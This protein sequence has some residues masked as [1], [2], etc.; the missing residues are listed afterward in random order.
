[1]LNMGIF[2]RL[3]IANR[4]FY[5]KE[6]MPRKGESD[7]LSDTGGMFLNLNINQGFFKAVQILLS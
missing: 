1:M 7:G 5:E 6:V 3:H 4:R 2:H